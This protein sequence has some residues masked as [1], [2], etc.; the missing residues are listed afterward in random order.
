M[1]GVA[2]PESSY[3]QFAFPNELAPLQNPDLFNLL[4]NSNIEA[5]WPTE[6]LATQNAGA[7]QYIGLMQVLTTDPDAWDWTVNT[8]DAVNLFSGT[9]SPNKIQ[10]EVTYEDDVINGTGSGKTK[11]PGQVGL[12]SL[13][14]YEHENMALVLYGGFVSGLCGSTPS[15]TC[16][17]SQYYIPLLWH[18][19]NQ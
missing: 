17:N 15:Q 13:T 11:I 19:K 16:L 2:E 3:H 7:G 6:N 18:P 5:K 8:S 4:H 14:G 1:T 12:R 9:V 10:L